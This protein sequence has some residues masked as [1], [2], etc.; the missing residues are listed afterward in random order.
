[1]VR[2]R[3]AK[4]ANI[5][6]AGADIIWT[7]PETGDVLVLGW[8]STFG[9]IK[10]ATLELQGTGVKASACHIRYLNPL[11][12]SLGEKLRNFKHV[13]IPEMNLGQ[14]RSIVRNRYL[15]DAKGL[16]KVRGQPFTIGEI[17]S[18]V[19]ALVSGKAGEY[20]VEMAAD[21]DAGIGGG[22]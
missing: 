21:I 22:G 16:N 19:N 5:K 15:I 9:A 13:L 2:L 3:A 8:G 12:A 18:G 11:P 14:L 20:E 4:V 6:P 7:G 17:V 1:M 10:A